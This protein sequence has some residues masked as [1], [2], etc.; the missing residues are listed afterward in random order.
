MEREIRVLIADDHAIVREGLRMLLSDQA[1]M[2]VVGEAAD[3]ADAVEAAVRLQP[4]VVL[5]DILM[6][7]GSGI[8]ALRRIRERCPAVRVV[9]LTSLADHAAV[10]EAMSAG[11]TGYL[12]KDVSPAD[13]A[14]AVR[15]AAA[16][17][18]TLHPEA[19][20]VLAQGPKTARGAPLEDL[21][22]RERS[23]L[24]LLAQGR[25]NRQIA[26]RLGLTE[27]TVKG[28]LTHL[29]D[30]LGVDDRTQAV[31]FALERGIV[32]KS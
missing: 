25:S 27:G 31:L 32:R 13:L 23:V 9:M 8:E 4:D 19:A 18:A 10:R 28:Y 21:T 30:K 16:S 12:L 6:P 5:L 29:F 3:A 22:P 2:T 7:G 14:R 20:R 17:R 26:N 1:G 15:D 24:E 11:A